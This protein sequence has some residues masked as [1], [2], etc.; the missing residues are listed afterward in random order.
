MVI[1]WLAVSAVAQE[2]E[3][4]P[5]PPPPEIVVRTP[6]PE[7]EAEKKKK[8]KKQ[9]KERAARPEKP[10]KASAPHADPGELR[11][12]V[13]FGLSAGLATGVGPTLGIPLGQKARMQITTLP[14]AFPDVGGG[15]SVGLRLQQFLGKNPRS[16]LYLV[17]GAAIHGW[18]NV[19]SLWGV[20]L[21]MGVETRKDVTSGRTLW[22]DL[23]LTVFG[24]REGAIALIPL[25]QAGVAWEF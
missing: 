15:G 23:T 25:P 6:A 12:G 22:A 21:G 19:G 10:A 14:M 3:R 8:K 7:P 16:R 11:N 1:S 4:P 2:G 20:G 9:K 18:S 24:G 17:E 13:S 5:P